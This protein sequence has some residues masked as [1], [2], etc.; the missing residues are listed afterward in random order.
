V[1]GVASHFAPNGFSTGGEAIKSTLSADA[2][3]I[4]VTTARNARVTNFPPVVATEIQAPS[5]RTIRFHIGRKS[6][7][8]ISIAGPCHLI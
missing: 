8:V 7:Y 1:N 3:G 2:L 6:G 4:D 5:K